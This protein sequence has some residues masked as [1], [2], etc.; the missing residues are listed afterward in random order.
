M[1]ELNEH[2]EISELKKDIAKDVAKTSNMQELINTN[3]MNFYKRGILTERKRIIKMLR[4]HGTVISTV[5]AELMIREQ[6]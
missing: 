6:G 2:A 3:A 5:R 1:N 4:D